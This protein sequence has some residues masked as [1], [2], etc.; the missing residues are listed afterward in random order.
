MDANRS[1]P[2]MAL[3]HL[4]SGLDQP[5]CK[6]RN[7][8]A[9]LLT[10]C[11]FIAAPM[12]K[13]AG[14]EATN[15][16]SSI[17][18]ILDAGAPAWRLNGLVLP[19]QQS[20]DIDFREVQL[21][22]NGSALL[23]P[24]ADGFERLPRESLRVFVGESPVSAEGIAVL[25]RRE[26]GRLQGSWE[27]AGLR[28]EL[29][30]LATDT[31]L[32]ATERSVLPIPGNPFE[33]DEI[34]IEVDP[35]TRMAKTRPANQQLPFDLSAVRQSAK[36]LRRG[37]S[38]ALMGG[39]DGV[40]AIY[41]IDVP[42]G[43]K[44]FRA[45]I[46]ATA[47]DAD[48]YV[49]DADDLAGNSFVC[50]PLLS[51]SEES[52]V[53]RE[54]NS[55][56]QYLLAVHT[57]SQYGSLSLDFSTVSNLNPDQLYGA[58]I[59]LDTDYE[60]VQ[61]LGSVGDVQAYFASLFAYL[62]VTYES[63]ISTRLLI[64]DQIIPQ[65]DADDVY[66]SWTSC[67]DRI[68][69]VQ[70]RYGGNASIERSLLAHFSPS[71]GN[72]GVA[73]TPPT[74]ANTDN[75]TGV[76]CNKTYG[77][78]V[79]NVVGVAPGAGA[80]ISNSWDAV[81]A[82]HELGHN[83]SSPHSHCYG[84]L[85]G[86]SLSQ[87]E[88]PVD[89]CYVSES[90]GYENLCAKGTASLPGANALTGGTAGNGN[91][92]IMSYCHLLGGGLGN[93][94]RTFGQGHDAGVLPERVAQRMAMAVENASALPYSCV[95]VVDE[96]TDIT[97]TVI[98]TG[99]G[100]GSIDSAPGGI[101][102]G[103]DCSEVFTAETAV[104][105]T[106]TAD[107]G[108]VFAGW[109]GACSGSELTCEVT[110]NQST[111]VTASFE[112]T[113]AITALQ[114]NVPTAPLSGA[115]GSNQD[116]SFEVAEGT[117]RL[118]VTLAVDSGDPDIFV[119]TSFP[120][121][122][123]SPIYNDPP[124]PLCSSVNYPED[125]SCTFDDPTPGTYYIRVN[126]WS[127]FSGAVL[128]ANTLDVY[129]VTPSA[130]SGGSVSPETPVPVTDGDTATFNLMPDTG[131]RVS[132]V[133]GSCAGTY[134]AG[135]TT[136]T[137][138]PVTSD[139]SVAVAFEVDPNFPLPPTIT[140]IT[141]SPSDGTIE[142]AF[143]PNAAGGDADTYTATCTPATTEELFS[144]QAGASQ[145]HMSGPMSLAMEAEHASPLFR[146]SGLRCGSEHMTS[147]NS[148][149]ARSG[150]MLM[151]SQS[152]CSLSQT[153]IADEYG[154]LSVGAYVIPIYFHVIYTSSNEGWIPED[155]IRAQVDVLNEDF[156]AI[157]NTSIR[158]ELAGISY[159]QNDEWFTDSAADEAAYKAA[160][161]VDPSRYLNVYT[162]DASGYLGYATFPAQSAGSVLDGVVNLHSATGGRDNG[163]GSFD[164]GRTLV[165]EIGHYLGLWHTFQGNGGA[166]ENSYTSGDYIFDTPPHG[167][168]D[169]GCSAASVCGGLSS[170]ENF[171]NYSN[172][173]CMDRFTEEQSNRMVCSLV[174]YRPSLF[175]IDSGGALSV[176]GA[177][178]PL[179]LADAELDTS[180]ACSVTATN[181][182]GSSQPS[183]SVSVLLRL[184]TTPPSAPIISRWEV[185]DGEI[186]LQVAPSDD[187]Y[188][189]SYEASCSDGTNTYTAVTTG[190]AL[191]VTGLTNDVGYACSVV[192]INGVG[193]SAATVYPTEI[194]PEPTAQ[195]LPIWLLYEA[196]QSSP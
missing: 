106:A 91:G 100:S 32:S 120:P 192:A 184:V 176:T 68:L 54:L 127:A 163:Y 114:D 132:S 136:Y 122:T 170:I 48:L 183:N 188:V 51:G 46:S 148:L 22:A 67:G 194:V 23:R 47:G 61:A 128:T 93:V 97:L 89:A 173:S 160:L 16:R 50:A 152:D 161:G 45:A 87:S 165:H 131:Y 130:G 167:S 145:P 41:R 73:Y 143:S 187:I 101:A 11:W 65:S 150:G 109:G 154:P 13:A 134:E 142:V 19:T 108:S 144:R 111:Q 62:N 42:A 179:I 178:S 39:V 153:V 94:G 174:N 92:V 15:Q 99:Q 162:N 138:G 7:I 20:L 37:Q 14:P 72:C 17:I 21:Y 44:G 56:G 86:G 103:E 74:Q 102:C 185:G 3:L 105:L 28:Y 171:M 71:G 10:L 24:T 113:S 182:F 35:A 141:A 29:E 175:R 139:C 77:Y 36:Q 190:S 49:I 53:V 79:N 110:L 129:T 30:M 4:C 40:P 168:P 12:T 80:P 90:D 96:S 6:W 124:Y 31:Q 155:R 193:E 116:F 164:Q 133:S 98:K 104:T 57:A 81:V 157:F 63:E 9:V 88:S 82:A 70:S 119:D 83:F 25:I 5:A 27:D 2:E 166:C 34:R 177:G 8:V 95:S 43:A 1:S 195:G 186:W 147:R 107:A 156:G 55:S 126:G 76:L 123:N 181:S 64:G 59:A 75:Y 169:Y 115:A 196:S 149:G 117:S 189:S 60:M 158:F 118:E 58:T 146:E 180:Y 191:T 78:S 140:S 125:E 85:N 121:V 18:P 151:A 137:A 66:E 135:A 159:T 69:E 33:G 52:C 112:S 172:D 84:N 26:D 38:A